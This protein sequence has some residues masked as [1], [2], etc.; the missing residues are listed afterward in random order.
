MV[1]SGT[2]I[3]TFSDSSAM[4]TRPEDIS[5]T[6]EE[7]DMASSSSKR[8]GERGSSWTAKLT[9]PRRLP[10]RVPVTLRPRAGV[11]ERWV[12][13]S[14]LQVGMMVGKERRL[15]RERRREEILLCVLERWWSETGECFGIR[16][17]SEIS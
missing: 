2:E 8:G 6:R 11:I 7:V 9:W 14:H 4:R 3:G 13:L 12:F 17:L 15:R 10:K 16:S 1:L 5:L